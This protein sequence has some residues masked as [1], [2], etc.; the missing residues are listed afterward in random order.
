M[1]KGKYNDLRNDYFRSIRTKKEAEAKRAADEIY[2][3]V[4]A[5]QDKLYK[6]LE[7]K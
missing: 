7:K 2:A 3:K 1:K 5:W 6:E 4:K